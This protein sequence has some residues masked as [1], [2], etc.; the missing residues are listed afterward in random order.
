MF[1]IYIL[2]YTV[3]TQIVGAIHI[4]LFT[5]HIYLF[6]FLLYVLRKLRALVLCRGHDKYL[7][8]NY[9]EVFQVTKKHFYI[10][11][12]SQL[13]QPVGDQKDH[14]HLWSNSG[15]PWKMTFTGILLK[16]NG[17]F[18]WQIPGRL[19]YNNTIA[20]LPKSL[21]R[22]FKTVKQW[23]QRSNHGSKPVFYFLFSHISLADNTQSFHKLPLQQACHIVGA[24]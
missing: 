11:Y 9:L 12:F 4:Y 6:C 3:N 17:E 15:S 13:Q 16:Q 7:L 8:F 1:S 22:F 20:V 14:F 18:C 23:W 10:Y 21:P 5:Y 24:Q 2:S 19:T